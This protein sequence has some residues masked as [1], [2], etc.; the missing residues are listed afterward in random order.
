MIESRFM[1]E[2]KGEC[3]EFWKKDAQNR[4]ERFKEE[5]KTEVNVENGVARWMS[6]NEV[7]PEEVAEIMEFGGCEFDRDATRVM[8]AK[9][10]DG[11]LS[12]YREAMEHYEP[13]DED[14]AEMWAAFGEGAEVV[15]V[16][17]GKVIKL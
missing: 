10:L 6:N 2:I 13:S 7:I 3:G 1:Q 12:Q 14:L 11:F 4:L 5:F 16:I 15:N 17:T 9:E 8:R